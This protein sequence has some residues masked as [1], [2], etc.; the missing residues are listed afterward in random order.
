MILLLTKHYI[1]YYWA[2]NSIF[3]IIFCSARA[4]FLL[5]VGYFLSSGFGSN[6]NH[7]FLV[8]FIIFVPGID[9]VIRATFQRFQNIEFY[10]YLQF[11]ITRKDLASSFI[12]NNILDF[13]NFYILIILI[14]FIVK[15]YFTFSLLLF[16]LI[17]ITI[18]L[19]SMLDYLLVINIKIFI[20]RNAIT[21][22]IVLLTLILA[23]YLFA[24]S[25][26]VEFT[27]NVLINSF[28]KLTCSL[29][30]LIIIISKITVKN[31]INFFYLESTPTFK[32][33]IPLGIKLST[34]ILSI[35]N[36]FEAFIIKMI[37]R[38]KRS[39]NNFYF[40]CIA[41]I[42]AMFFLI[43]PFRNNPHL[44]IAYLFMFITIFSVGF[45]VYFTQ[46]IFNYDNKYI[47]LLFL[48]KNGIKKYLNSHTNLL[49]LISFIIYIITTPLMIL[50]GID[51]FLYNAIW[52]Y[53]L[54]LGVC[55]IM[56][57]S[58]FNRTVIN[59]DKSRFEG[60]SK[61]DL[62]QI[63]LLLILFTLPYFLYYLF[64]KLEIA[65]YFESVFIVIG[66]TFFITNKI[67]LSYF[68]SLVKK[69]KYRILHMYGI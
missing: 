15:F 35:D 13:Y 65:S 33:G 12:L 20:Q 24:H 46:Y 5:L 21:F 62:N 2:K 66:V 17:L 39:K 68:S 36:T 44:S 10:K 58:L 59:V 37:F 34:K 25:I 3:Q 52:V 1:K 54:G 49:Y 18:L 55:V 9:L 26:H 40:Y 16:A 51:L 11:P 56:F 32:L 57:K 19:I 48:N 47:S 64:Q 30:V 22:L 50:K 38:N 28:G 31:L 27:E 6:I 14:P 67:W 53:N 7:H 45:G 29:V 69:R 42:V 23:I 4:I 43:D 63:G 60:Y 41:C 8:Y 61:F